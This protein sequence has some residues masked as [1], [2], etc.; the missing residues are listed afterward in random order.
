MSDPSEL[1][2]KLPQEVADTASTITSSVPAPLLP[3]PSDRQSLSFVGDYRLLRRIG[4]GTFGQ[5]WRA[6]APGGTEVAIKIITQS[7]E[8][9]EGKQELKALEHV[10]RLRHTYLVQTHAYRIQQ[11]QLYIVMEL[12]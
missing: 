3:A 4:A 7:L 8:A 1:Y 9:K 10:K 2:K 5:V 12:A 6:E 11:E